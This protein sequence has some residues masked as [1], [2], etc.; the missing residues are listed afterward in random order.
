MIAITGS[1]G[2]TTT[3]EIVKTLLSDD[4]NVLAPSEGYNTEIG[5]P[6]AIFNKKVPIKANSLIEWTKIIFQCFVLAFFP[7]SFPEKIILEFGAD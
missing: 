5:V 3:K 6:L 1:A 7:K 4:F 2:K